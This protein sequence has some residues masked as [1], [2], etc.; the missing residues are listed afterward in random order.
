MNKALLQ[1]YVKLCQLGSIFSV[2]V[3]SDEEIRRT[4]ELYKL[5]FR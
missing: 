3:L 5:L 4:K 2:C 1:E